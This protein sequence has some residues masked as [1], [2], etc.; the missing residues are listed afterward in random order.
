MMGS[1]VFEAVAEDRK[2]DERCFLRELPPSDQNAVF[3]QII[4]CMDRPGVSEQ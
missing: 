1:Y 4:G 3:L 2:G